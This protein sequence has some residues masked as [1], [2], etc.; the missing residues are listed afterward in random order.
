MTIRV[1]T[2]IYTRFSRNKMNTRKF[3]LSLFEELSL[4]FMCSSSASPSPS[5]GPLSSSK[6]LS[7][8]SHFVITRLHPVLFRNLDFHSHFFQ[9]I[10][11]VTDDLLNDLNLPVSVPLDENRARIISIRGKNFIDSAIK[12]KL[13]KIVIVS[14]TALTPVLI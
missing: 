4:R 7:R 9:H 12:E 3:L 2:H 11:D 1:K 14:M 6:F 13:L 10:I 8:L 5:P